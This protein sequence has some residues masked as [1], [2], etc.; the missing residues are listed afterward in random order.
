MEGKSL[1]EHATMRAGAVGM[2]HAWA[3]MGS[4]T[5]LQA[6]KDA[7]ELVGAWTVL[8]AASGAGL[9]HWPNGLDV[10]RVV[11]RPNRLAEIGR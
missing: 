7:A 10:D 8:Q 4:T 11:G 1:V 6:D 3:S 5:L 9:A 2:A